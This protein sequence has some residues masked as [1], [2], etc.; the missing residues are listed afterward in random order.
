MGGRDAPLAPE[1]SIRGVRKVIDGLSL[2]KSGKF[3][4]HDGST[5][6]W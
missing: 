6:A 2:E 4:N 5:I 1:A 3:L